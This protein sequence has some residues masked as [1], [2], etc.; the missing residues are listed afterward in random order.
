MEIGSYKGE[1][2]E[3]EFDVARDMIRDGKAS[4]VT[5]VPAG[6][7][8]IVEQQQ[9]GKEEVAEVLSVPAEM[10]KPVSKRKR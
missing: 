4:L 6:D 3:F 9:F 5:S 2:R 8:E 7:V 1:V 10:V